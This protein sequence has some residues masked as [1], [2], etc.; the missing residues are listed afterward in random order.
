MKGWDF[1]WIKKPMSID[2][3]IDE[4]RN[5]WMDKSMDE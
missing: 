4:Y 5:Q 1:G 2:D 3:S